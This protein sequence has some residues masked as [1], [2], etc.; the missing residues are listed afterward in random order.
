[1]TSPLT[2]PVGDNVECNGL[3]VMASDL[4]EGIAGVAYPHDGCPLHSDLVDLDL[5]DHSGRRPSD[6]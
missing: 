1:M 2:Q 3:C 6:G 4:I 5:E